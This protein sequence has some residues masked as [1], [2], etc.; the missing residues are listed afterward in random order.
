MINFIKSKTNYTFTEEQIKTKLGKYMSEELNL[1]V[2]VSTD[3]N[4][5]EFTAKK[6]TQEGDKYY[7]TLNNGTIVTLT[8]SGN[9]YY[10]YACQLK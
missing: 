7:I 9:Q 3:T 6:G 2:L 8:K 4:Y 10:F 1:F 5:I